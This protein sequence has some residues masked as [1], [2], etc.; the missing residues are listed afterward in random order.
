M[1]P[2]VYFKWFTRNQKYVLV[3]RLLTVVLTD[4]SLNISLVCGGR[5]KDSEI[6]ETQPN[7]RKGVV[8]NPEKPD[9]QVHG[10]VYSKVCLVTK[11]T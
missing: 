9:F 8:V 2:K 11:W 7:R 10:L 4:D 1:R 5:S 6:T 3:F